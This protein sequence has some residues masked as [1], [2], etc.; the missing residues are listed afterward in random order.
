MVIA[1][2]VICVNNIEGRKGSM[3]VSEKKD[4][5]CACRWMG[6]FA[7]FQTSRDSVHLRFP[8]H[9][10]VPDRNNNNYVHDF[11]ELNV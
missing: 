10:Y 6:A 5:R 9:S 2:F 4:F 8:S 7:K 3:S 11:D 1:P